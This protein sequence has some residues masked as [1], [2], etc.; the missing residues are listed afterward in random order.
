MPQKVPTNGKAVTISYTALL[1]TQGTNIFTFRFLVRL[2]R[3]LPDQYQLLNSMDV[4]INSGRPAAVGGYNSTI[5]SDTIAIPNNGWQVQEGDQFAVFVY[6]DC[7]NDYCPANVNLLNRDDCESTVYQPFI[8]PRSRDPGLHNISKSDPFVRKAPVK[9]NMRI[10]IGEP[11][12][13]I[14]RIST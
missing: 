14:Y 2:M 7:T 8:F 13:Y 9:V 10:F 4:E 12:V 1:N 5:H 3:E 6:N 11:S